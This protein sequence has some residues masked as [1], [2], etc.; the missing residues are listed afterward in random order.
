MSTVKIVNYVAGNVDLSFLKI[1]GWSELKVLINKVAYNQNV[2]DLRYPF[3]RNIFRERVIYQSFIKY[4]LCMCP[5]S[6]T[7]GTGGYPGFPLVVLAL[8]IC[9][10]L[11]SIICQHSLATFQ[12]T[13]W[14]STTR[15]LELQDPALNYVQ[16]WP[17]KTY[18]L[19]ISGLASH[20]FLLLKLNTCFN[21]LSVPSFLSHSIC[22]VLT[23]CV[24]SGIS[25][26]LKPCISAGSALDSQSCNGVDTQH[27]SASGSTHID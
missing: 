2:L 19:W 8:R 6:V 1:R 15:Q 27:S 26:N 10:P 11:V 9:C 12:S 16:S 13:A 17:L 3:I 14:C 24:G 22:S 21:V 7:G 23:L 25:Q 20:I 4:H 18:N 5:W